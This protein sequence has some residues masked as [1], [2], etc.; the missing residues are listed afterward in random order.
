MVAEGK[1]KTPDIG[2]RNTTGEVGDAVCAKLREIA[3]KTA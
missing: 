3:G 2:G 1:Y